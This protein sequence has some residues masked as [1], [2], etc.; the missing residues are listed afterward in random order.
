V[1]VDDEDFRR[2]ELLYAEGKYWD[3]HEAWEIVWNRETD[4]ARRDLVQGLILIAAAVHKLLVMKRPDRA[5]GMIERAIAKLAPLPATFEGI[6]VATLRARATSWGLA[7]TAA[8]AA[9]TLDLGA[10]DCGS[11]PRIVRA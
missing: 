2:G 1:I 6:D 10:F 5:P 7:V 4:A 3:A 11:L 8:H 9:G